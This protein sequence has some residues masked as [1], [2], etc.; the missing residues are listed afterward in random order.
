[1]TRPPTV[2]KGRYIP[3]TKALERTKDNEAWLKSEMQRL[4]KNG[5]A[6]QLVKNS[7]GQV[8]LYRQIVEADLRE[9]PQEWLKSIQSNGLTRENLKNKFGLEFPG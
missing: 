7:K 5:S 6:C 3:V 8:I 4:E 9:A 2:L 1:M